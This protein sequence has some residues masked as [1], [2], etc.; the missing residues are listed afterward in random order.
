MTTRT[1]VGL[2]AVAAYAAAIVAANHLTHRYGLISVG[3]GLTA[4]AGTYSAGAA[5]MLRNQVQDLLGRRFVI[6]A[7]LLGAALSALTSPSLALASG[8]AFCVSELCDTAAYTPL[9]KRGW[10]RAVLPA[11]LL[12]ATVDSLLF[13]WLAGFPVTVRGVAGQLLGKG[14]AVWVP[15]LLVTLLR[16]RRRA[17]PGHPVRS[18]GA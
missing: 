5:L 17:L 14:W 9:R 18:E 13:L 1:R 12:G 4:T 10:A 2:L 8:I 3:F 15:V 7:I 11:S 16:G 6:G